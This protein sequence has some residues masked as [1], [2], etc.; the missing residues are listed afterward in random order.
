[1]NLIK[2]GH[3]GKQFAHIF[4]F[5][6]LF[7]LTFSNSPIPILNLVL[8]VPCHMDPNKFN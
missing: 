6:F 4:S 1:M 2:L 5:S 8:F 7:S 3:R